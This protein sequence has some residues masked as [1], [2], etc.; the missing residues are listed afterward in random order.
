[1]KIITSYNKEKGTEQG[2]IISMIHSTLHLKCG[3]CK[4]YSPVGGKTFTLKAQVINNMVHFLYVSILK[5]TN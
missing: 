4:S 2:G 1:M 5:Y 3:F